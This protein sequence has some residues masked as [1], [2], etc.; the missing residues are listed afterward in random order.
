[1]LDVEFGYRYSSNKLS[2]I[3]N[4]YN[5]QYK[6]QLILTGDVNDV[7]SPIRINVPKS[8]RRIEMT[9]DIKL[10][11]KFN[12]RFNTTLSQNKIVEFTEAIDDWD[13]Q[14]Q[15]NESHENTDI[16]FSP[17]IVGGGQLIFTPFISE[18]R[19]KLDLALVSKYVGEQHLDNTSSDYG[20]LEDY[21]IHDLRINYFLKLNYL[22]KWC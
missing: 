18:E 9:A 22:R 5:M 2:L 17:S 3:A 13:L 7:G 8:F 12:L 6:N 16:A 4:L 10:N 21:F 20:K 15:V 14:T 19:G 1:M 11:K